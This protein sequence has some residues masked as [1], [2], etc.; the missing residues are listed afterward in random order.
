MP[1]PANP[2]VV[3]T[4]A[5]GG[6]GRAFCLELA[7]RKARIIAADIDG[8]AAEST[9]AAVRAA[10]GEAESHTCDVAKLADVER[11]AA[12]AD[13]AYGGTDL[14]V[15]NA[16]V[17]VAGPFEQVGIPDWEW[18]MAINLWGVIYGCRTFIPRFKQQGSGAILNVASAAGLLNMPEMGPYNVTKA[19]VVALSETLCAELH[20]HKIGVTVLCPTFFQTNIVKSG[21]NTNSSQAAFAEKLMQRS[22]LQADGVARFALA[23]VDA[24]RLFAVPHRDGAWLWRL[25]RL[26]PERFYSKLIPDNI[27]RVRDRKH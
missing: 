7:R 26:H 3:V 4:G 23:A 2:R 19:G 12:A 27:G 15:N 17:A 11:I 9:A 24:R 10:G 5:G 21:R 1:L 16:G 20:P 14:I 6:L 25:K 18:I 8:G 22:K 13:A